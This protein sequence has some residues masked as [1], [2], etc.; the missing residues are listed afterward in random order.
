M[1]LPHQV[2]QNISGLRILP[3]LLRKLLSE[4]GSENSKKK[5]ADGSFSLTE[6]ICHLRDLEYEGYLTR[7]IKILNEDCPE[8]VEFDGTKVASER[9]YQSQDPQTA[10]QAFEENRAASIS[11]LE[12][13]SP[14]QLQRNGRFGPFGMIT[15]EQVIE[16]M[17][18]HD[19]S[20]MAELET[21]QKEVLN[22]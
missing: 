3:K 5:P 20:H 9:N 10:L 21:L 15:L 7:I 17:L 4:F 1:Q 18:E 19:R 2:E 16:R 14:D 12:K 6:Q 13:V 8:L 11:Q 22:S